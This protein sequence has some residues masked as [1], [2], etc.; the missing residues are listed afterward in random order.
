MLHEAFGMMGQLRKKLT[1]AT[2]VVIF[3]IAL[4]SFTFHTSNELV[5]LSASLFFMGRSIR[6]FITT[7]SPETNK[8]NNHR[9]YFHGARGK[10]PLAM[11]RQSCAVE[12][13]ARYNPDRPIEVFISTDDPDGKGLPLDYST[14]P[15]L[16]IFE[17]FGNV[18]IVMYNQTEYFSGTPL[19]PW[20]RAGV[21]RNGSYG[22]VHL[23]DYFRALSAFRGG[24]LYLD[25][26]VITLKR[27]DEKFL[28]NFFSIQD[29][30]GVDFCSG[31]FHLQHDH[32]LIGDLIRDLAAKTYNPQDYTGYGPHFVKGF[33]TKHCGIKLPDLSS[34][35][36]KDLKVIP[37]EYFFPVEWQSWGIYFQ[38]MEESA[39]K[40]LLNKSYG[41]HVWNRFSRN[42]P[43]PWGSKQLYA[44][45]AAVHC[46][47]T[48]AANSKQSSKNAKM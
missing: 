27:L 11:I 4:F 37:R 21:W 23:S 31:V 39:S 15:W 44:S 7:W 1:S 34:N 9:I 40:V 47:L 29:K 48:V 45:L 12:S 36:C 18:A 35:Q 46:P 2:I 25:L 14:D 13:A 43:I 19:E 8:P 38:N 24:G 22:L 10:T 28:W 6:P 5:E 32:R 33:V 42:H 26:D 30:S 17:Q 3:L 41:V 16:Q 20:Y